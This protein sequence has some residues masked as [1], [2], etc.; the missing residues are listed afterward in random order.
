MTSEEFSILFS[1]TFS[2]EDVDPVIHSALNH[3][4]D[5]VLKV[6]PLAYPMDPHVA[7]LQPPRS[8]K[9]TNNTHIESYIHT[10]T[11]DKNR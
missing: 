9:V 7:L 4:R 10:E 8:P 1:H 5:V 2:F 11:R 6:V 3:I